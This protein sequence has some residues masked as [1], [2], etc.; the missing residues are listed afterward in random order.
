MLRHDM[1]AHHMDT[2]ES[3]AR[4]SALSSGRHEQMGLSPQS[5]E[6]DGSRGAVRH[7]RVARCPHLIKWREE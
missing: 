7:H 5:P 4:P 1:A 6:L 3:R 2:P